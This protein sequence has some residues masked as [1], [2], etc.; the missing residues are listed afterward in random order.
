[1]KKEMKISK[2]EVEIEFGDIYE[3]FKFEN[4]FKDDEKINKFDGMVDEYNRLVNYRYSLYMIL[5]RKKTINEFIDTKDNV[6]FILKK[7]KPLSNEKIIKIENE[8]HSLSII[9]SWLESIIFDGQN[10][11]SKNV[12]RKK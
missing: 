3:K 2:E 6:E 5:S 7:N 9:I 8:I 10:L 1:M 11:I 4:T 12:L